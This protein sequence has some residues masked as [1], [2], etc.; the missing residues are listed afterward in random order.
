MERFGTVL[1]DL[2]G[3]LLDTAPGIIRS[4]EETAAACGL[5]PFTPEE[6]RS[7]IGPPIE[8]SFRE[9]R[10]LTAEEAASAASVFRVCYPEKHLM[11]AEPYPG[12]HALLRTLRKRGWHIG[13]ATYKRDSYAQRLLLEKGITPLCDAVLGTTSPEQKK[14]DVIRLCLE[15]L[16][17]TVEET[18]LVGDTLHDLHG[19]REAGCAFVGVT[20][21][22]GFRTKDEILALGALGAADSVEELG[23]TLE[24]E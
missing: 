24:E 5:T 9:L 1:F 23:E 10:R 21:G 6:E 14:A 16:G 20:Y 19:A 7:M 11:E 4:I 13:V 15:K 3:T 8:R 17:G 2:D 22:F 18:I 12:I